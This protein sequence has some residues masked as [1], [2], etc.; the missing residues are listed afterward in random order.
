[1]PQRV[2]VDFASTGINPLYSGSLEVNPQAK[3]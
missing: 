3:P 1:M 2:K